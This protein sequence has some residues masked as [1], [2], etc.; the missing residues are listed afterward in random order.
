[1]NRTEMRN[2]KTKNLDKMSAREIAQVIQ[3]ENKN[4][5]SA[6]DPILDEIA[7][8]IDRIAERMRKGGR[9]FYVGCG[10]S[11][12]LGVLDASECPPTFGVSP[13]TV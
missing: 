7:C 9:L 1:M 11:G 10:T 5:V 6:L 8:V 2:P 3:E 12:R 4:A 13:D